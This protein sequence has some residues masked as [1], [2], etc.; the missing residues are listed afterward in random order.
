LSEK[1]VLQHYS[2]E[3]VG[4]LYSVEQDNGWFKP[5]G[6]WL[7]VGEAWK[8]FL[9]QTD[10]VIVGSYISYWELS[11]DSV[12]YLSTKEEVCSIV[13]FEGSCTA[14]PDWY[15]ISQKYKGVLFNPYLYELR[16]K[17][18]WYNSVDLPSAVVWDPTCLRRVA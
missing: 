6:F 2:H 4:E 15:G 8:E 14:L 3:E 18:S 1:L 7:S 10:S 11:L 13:L 9:E 17:L 16:H 5:E 12:L